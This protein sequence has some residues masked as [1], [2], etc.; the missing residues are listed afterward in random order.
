[1][2]PAE[3]SALSPAHLLFLATTAG[4][5]VLDLPEVGHLS[6]GQRFDA[7][8]LRPMTGSTY[9]VAMRHARD[10]DDALAKT[11]ALATS[12]DIAAVWID[13]KSVHGSLRSA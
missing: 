10:A 8:W 6:V 12:A 3:G 9:E 5:A 2:Y 11:F 7:Q 4:A 13:G 1:M